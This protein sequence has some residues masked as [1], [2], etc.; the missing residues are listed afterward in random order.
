MGTRQSGKAVGG[1]VRAGVL[2]TGAAVALLG[3]VVP[4]PAVGA[5]PVKGPALVVGATPAA[6]SASAAAGSASAAAG[7]GSAPVGRAT[8]DLGELAFEPGAPYRGRSELA[9]VVHYPQGPGAKGM[10]RGRHPLIVMQHGYWHTCADRAAQKRL[11]AAQKALA[12]AEKAGNAAE[13]ARQL[14]IIGKMSDR[15][16]A[17]PCRPGT[18][19]LPSGSGYD[20]LAR[21]LA[22]QGFVVVSMGANGIN[23]TSGGQAE[24]VYRARAGLINEHLELW[25]KLDAGKGPLKGRIKDPATG[26]A[27]D[28]SFTGRVDLGRVGTLGHSMGGGGVMEH[29]A[30]GRRG[31]WPAGVKVKAAMGLA[32]TATWE[33]EPITRVPL[34]VLWGTC[35]QVNTGEF[36]KW[37]KGRNTAPL[38]GITLTGG[39]HNYANTQWS[40]RGGQVGGADDAVP[41]TRP[42]RCVAQDGT[43][44]QHRGLDEAT[45]RKITQGY[46]VAFFRRHLLGDTSAQAL[47]T[48]RAKLPRV[49]DVT[50]VEYVAPR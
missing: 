31:D 19:P 4:A 35:D 22:R 24:S 48:G 17:W 2:V 9:A 5:A 38:H 10:A 3:A 12:D 30:D 36:V 45:Q 50:R 43:Q 41:G 21:D 28:A 34:A 32:P 1:R 44:K 39:N 15:L 29:A 16:W 18:A 46:T 23:A 14:E 40:P 42:G 26:R 33:N 11:T 27:S 49:P 20:Y 25:R 8:Y 47:L 37:N 13:E 7:A 6:G